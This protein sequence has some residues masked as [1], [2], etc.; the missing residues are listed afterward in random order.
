[1]NIRHA[2]RPPTLFVDWARFR[3]NSHE[4]GY[5]VLYLANHAVLCASCASLDRFRV[6]VTQHAF[7]EGSPEQCEQC[8]AEIKSSYGEPDA[9]D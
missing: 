1:M 4:H 2:T 9:S 3:L 8:D 6:R 7:W 5:S